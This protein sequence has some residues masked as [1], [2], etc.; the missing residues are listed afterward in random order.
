MGLN[1]E[2]K[3]LDLFSGIGGFHLAGEWVWGKDFNTICHVEIDNFCQKILKK[4]WPDV[5]I[6]SD[7]KK[8]NHNGT[9]IDLLT[10]GF[11]CQPFSCAG[12]QR[13]KED[14]RYLWP[15][16]LRVISGVRPTWIIGEN[17]AGIINMGLE[18]VL[19]DLEGENYEVQPFIIPACAVNAPHRRDRVWIVAN[20]RR[21]HGERVEIRRKPKRQIFSQ[22][23]AIMS[24]RS[25]SDDGKR[26]VTNSEETK[27]K[28]SRRTR[29]G[30]EGFTN[31]DFDASDTTSIRLQNRSGMFPGL[32]RQEKADIK[33]TVTG[34][35]SR[36]KTGAQLWQEPWLEVATRLCR[37]DDGLPRQMD[38]TNRLR[39]LGNAIV[40]QVVV[41]IMQAIKELK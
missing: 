14:D 39:A 32:Y 22:E 28:S 31:N 12:K 36:Q 10:G 18:Q 4:H 33:N 30:R 34:T 17:V 20:S 11:P 29:T 2:I 35:Y 16:M 26:N 41:P 7:I 19:S 13:G 9:T 21:A 3:H 37:V 5:P 15:E 23:D 27:R 1:N 25:I 38:R 8:Y 6:I 40:P 24:K